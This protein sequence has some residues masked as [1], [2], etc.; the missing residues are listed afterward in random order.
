MHIRDQIQACGAELHA[1]DSS[2]TKPEIEE[3]KRLKAG[4]T[5][6]HRHRG[7]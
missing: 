6:R 4:T 3:I 7:W 5:F 1:W 2:K